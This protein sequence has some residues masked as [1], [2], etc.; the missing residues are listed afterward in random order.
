MHDSI[1]SIQEFIEKETSIPTSVVGLGQSFSAISELHPCPSHEKE[2]VLG[3][4][5]L[6]TLPNESCLFDGSIYGFSPSVSSKRKY[7]VGVHEYGSLLSDDYSSIGNQI[8]KIDDREL[9]ESQEGY[10]FRCVKKNCDVESLIGKSIAIME[11]I[12]SRKTK[13]TDANIVSAGIIARA[14][15]VGTNKKK[16][17]TCSGRTLWEERDLKGQNS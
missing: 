8:V 16:I 2:K 11:A 3:V 13:E 5:R 1:N 6:S 7:C 15:T 4:V 10:A 12:D 14:S 9:N 17:C